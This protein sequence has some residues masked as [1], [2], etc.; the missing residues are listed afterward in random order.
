M[1]VKPFRKPCISFAEQAALDN[2]AV[3]RHWDHHSP[4]HPGTASD[5]AA[6]REGWAAMLPDGIFDRHQGRAAL[7]I[8]DFGGDARLDTLERVGLIRRVAT[9]PIKW[10]KT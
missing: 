2:N 1:P 4:K 8:S 6:W 5:I 9:R 7:G 3:K 10:E